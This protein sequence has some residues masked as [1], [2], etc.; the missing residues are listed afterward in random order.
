MWKPTSIDPKPLWLPH[1]A[2]IQE[3]D[4]KDYYIFDAKEQIWI[5]MFSCNADLFNKVNINKYKY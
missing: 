1:G 3:D 2:I 4:T 5:K